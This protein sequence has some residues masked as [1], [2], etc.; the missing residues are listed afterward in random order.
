MYK[1]LIFENRT[2]AIFKTILLLVLLALLYYSDL[3]SMVLDWADKKEYSHG[4]LIPLISLY[5]IWTKRDILRKTE[6]EPDFKG[7]SIL[8]L[9]VLLL[10]VGRVGFDEFTRRASIII[11]I[12]GLAH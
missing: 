11:T 8:F 5:I 1:T 12:I 9:G 4:F 10:M 3:Y 2:S 7:I 6:V